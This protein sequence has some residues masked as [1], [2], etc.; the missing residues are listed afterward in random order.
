MLVLQAPRQASFPQ[1][2]VMSESQHNQP[3]QTGMAV[4][5]IVVLFGALFVGA[6][7]LL[8]ARI[9]TQQAVRELEAVRMAMEAR[10]QEQAAR[11]RAKATTPMAENAH[12]VQQADRDPAESASAR[13]EIAPAESSEPA[14]VDDGEVQAP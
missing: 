11:Q 3:C 14:P 2:T 13:P 1:Q 5:V 8:W 7:G 12:S 4:L 6:G 10:E 9:R